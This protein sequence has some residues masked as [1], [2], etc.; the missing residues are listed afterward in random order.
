M[1]HPPRSVY[2]KQTRNRGRGVFAACRIA[3]AEVI[4]EVPVLV[5]P[6]EILWMPQGTAELANYVFEWSPGKVALALG[7]GS[8]YN[9]SFDPNARVDD[10]AIRRKR[11][12][13]IRDIEPHEEILINYHG[14][15]DD[16]RPL[17]FDVS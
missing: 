12:V 16:R 4:E 17:G 1:F 14:A 7:Y 13:A 15:V 9:H 3:A 8:L 11:F 6:T 2:V 10:R 5:L